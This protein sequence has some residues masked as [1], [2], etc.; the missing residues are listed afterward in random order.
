MLGHS[1]LVSVNK[2]SFLAVLLPGFTGV[3]PTA[4]V[5]VTGTR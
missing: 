4:A 1:I 5:T 2:S 3:R